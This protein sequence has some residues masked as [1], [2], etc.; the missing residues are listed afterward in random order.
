MSLVVAIDEIKPNQVK[1]NGVLGAGSVLTSNFCRATVDAPHSPSAYLNQG[2]PGRV[3]GAHFHVADQ[4][5]IVVAGKGKFGRH[6]VSPYYVHYSRA[7]TPYGPL[8]VDKETGWAFITLRSRYD[9]G[10]QL[11]SKAADKL[12]QMP[13]RQ[14][15]QVSK[16]VTFPIQSSGIKLNDIAEI[17]GDPGLFAHTLTMAPHT[18]TIAPDPSGGDGQ[19]I[20]VVKGSLL[21]DDRERKA[22]T[23]AFVRP[24]E[25]AFQI[26]AGAEGLEAFILNLP[27]VKPRDE[28]TTGPSPAAGLKK[29]QCTLCSFAYDEA[30]G[31][32]E[33]GIPPGTRWQEVPDS[34]SCP[35]CSASKSDFEMVEV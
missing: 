10:Q 15:W 20:V 26:C 23:I 1:R 12:K 5:Q 18:Q 19:F 7:Y 30:L 32:P 9:P 6:Q 14:P 25:S 35:D 11:L 21:H 4:F 3:T 22:M 29:W 8:Q 2:E 16:Q 34:W 28:I 17:K 33:E 13:D 31:M 24:E 27:Q